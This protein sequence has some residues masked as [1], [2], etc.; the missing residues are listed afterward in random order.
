MRLDNVLRLLR[1]IRDPSR[2]VAQVRCPFDNFGDNLVAEAI[3]AMLPGLS[4]LTC[5]PD[6]KVRTLDAVLG[7]R[8]VYDYCGLG[9]GTLIF[10]RR[11]RWLEAVEYLI[12]RTTPLFA[13][14][15]GVIDP[16]F[17]RGLPGVTRHQV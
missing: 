17:L 10:A 2:S 5:F 15:I 13:F 12:R 7:L 14:G 3:E 8:R 6:Q 1:S 9:G 4:L 16:A 11:G